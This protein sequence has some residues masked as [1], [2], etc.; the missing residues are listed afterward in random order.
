MTIFAC[1]MTAISSE[2]R[3][4]YD[5]LMADLTHAWPTRREIANG[6]EFTVE[7]DAMPLIEL[8]EWI[9][10]EARCCPFFTFGLEVQ[11]ESQSAT[12]RLMGDEGVK[13]F[14][15]AEFGLP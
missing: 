11:G 1:N 9:A 8:A 5:A 6:Y 10:L 15:R 7:L 3:H 13:E 4:R 14:I 2:Q 12:L